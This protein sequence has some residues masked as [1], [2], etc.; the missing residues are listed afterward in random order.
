MKRSD[1]THADLVTLV[2]FAA[3]R[4]R[5]ASCWRCSTLVSAVGS[6]TSPRSPTRIA[7]NDRRRGRFVIAGAD[8]SATRN[9]SRR[10][11]RARATRLSTPSEKLL[12]RQSVPAR[13]GADPF[14]L[15]IALGDNRRL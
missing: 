12:R 2:A 8:T 7:C 4:R 13:Y 1:S 14:A 3:S 6:L 9:E 15:G 10:F 5:Q 11:S